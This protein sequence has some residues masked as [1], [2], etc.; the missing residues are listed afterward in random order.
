MVRIYQCKV[1]LS[2]LFDPCK[3]VLSASSA[4]GFCF[5]SALIRVNPR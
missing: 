2:D 5:R 4:V 3:S 1:V